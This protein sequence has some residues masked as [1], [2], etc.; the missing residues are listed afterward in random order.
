MICIGLLFD[1][2]G[3]FAM[4]GSALLVVVHAVCLI[5]LDIRRKA[6]QRAK[7]FSMRR[8]KVKEREARRVTNEYKKRLILENL[9]K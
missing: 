5:T 1:K 7:L 8:L 2:T 4:G 9:A 6:A 3:Y